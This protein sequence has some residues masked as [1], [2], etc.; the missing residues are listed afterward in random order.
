MWV[1]KLSNFQYLP[2]F[3][4]W[5]QGILYSLVFLICLVSIFYN[6]SGEMKAGRHIFRISHKDAITLAFLLLPLA[7]LFFSRSLIQR[8]YFLFIYPFP[9][10]VVARGFELLSSYA[11]SKKNGIKIKPIIFIIL[12]TIFLLNITTIGY[13][14][15][16]LEQTGGQGEYG[17]VLSD[18]RRV[19]D[20]II[21]HSGG[22]YVIDIRGV[23]ESLPYV[24]LF[25]TRSEV[26]TDGDL[27]RSYSIWSH[28]PSYDPPR[29]RIIEM[30]YHPVIVEPG[31]RIIFRARGII[32]LASNN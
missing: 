32:V 14:Y 29:Y 16:F 28:P 26:G 11:S 10:L 31:E 8:H 4:D 21:E 24:F 27:M 3:I 19:V 15:R 6:I 25:Q 13:A 17:T 22:N 2:S 9:L 7:Y 12:L 30:S 1:S 20:Y 18:K 23:Q 5:S